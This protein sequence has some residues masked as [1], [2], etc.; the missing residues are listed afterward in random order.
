MIAEAHRPRG[1]ESNGMAD[2][3]GR[4]IAEMPGRV[5]V[6]SSLSG[7]G[8]VDG[9]RGARGGVSSGHPVRIHPGRGPACKTEPIDERLLDAVGVGRSR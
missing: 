7:G 1:P 4:A 2:D 8:G 3:A 9:A 5:K 6:V